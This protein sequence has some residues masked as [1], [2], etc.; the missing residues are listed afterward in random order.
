LAGRRILVTGAVS[1]IGK[2]TAELFAAEGA[3]LALLDM[4][5]EP[6]TVVGKEL[7]AVSCLADVSDEAQV[8]TA[9]AAAADQLGGID[10]VVNAAGITLTG[11][12]GDTTLA[13]WRRLISVNLDGTFLVCR[14]CLPWLRQASAATI[15][16]IR[17]GQ[18]L[19][20]GASL[21]ACAA[22]KGGVLTLTRALAVEL[23]PLIRVN[24]VCP[25]IVDTPMVAGTVR[26]AAPNLNNYA[27][28]RMATALEVAQA[29]LFL[30]SHESAFV[31][32]TALA[33]DGARTFH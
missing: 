31:A 1:G 26:S 24:A 11:L 30:T 22:S 10:G 15:V 32:G 4:N 19:L 7:D 16:N 6:L 17:S 14:A 18:A 27:L 25:G 13:T 12:L 20:P 5:A 9:V 33:V 28:R 2:R 29:L 8:A 23:A 21:S 3:R